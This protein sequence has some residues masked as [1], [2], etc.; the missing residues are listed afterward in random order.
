MPPR[1]CA[2]LIFLMR[3]HSTRCNDAPAHAIVHNYIFTTEFFKTTSLVSFTRIYSHRRE[4]QLQAFTRPSS[5]LY[6][7]FL[8]FLCS[9]GDA[10]FTSTFKLDRWD[11]S[12]RNDRH[13]EQNRLTTTSFVGNAAEERSDKPPTKNFTLPAKAIFQPALCIQNC[14]LLLLHPERGQI[15]EQVRRASLTYTSHILY[16]RQQ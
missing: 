16:R 2:L 7:S 13:L 1:L 5:S 12:P 3:F 14:S 11:I 15:P 8:S 10:S 6:N 4:H 9:V